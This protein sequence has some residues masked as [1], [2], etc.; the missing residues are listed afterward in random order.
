MTEVKG[1]NRCDVTEPLGVVS[2][3]NRVVHPEELPPMNA[4]K[5][6]FC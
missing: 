4:S 6:I 1:S 5:Q 2:N 3:D